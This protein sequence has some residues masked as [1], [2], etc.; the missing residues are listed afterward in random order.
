MLQLK[1][2]NYISTLIIV[3][4]TKRERRPVKVGAFAY[5][6]VGDRFPRCISAVRQTL[7]RACDR[8]AIRSSTCSVP[9]ESRTV[10][11]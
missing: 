1:G 11:G 2:R 6:G 5:M 8:S 4:I 7:S 10:P 9:M 3:S